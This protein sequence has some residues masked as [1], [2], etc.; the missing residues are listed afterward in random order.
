M[1]SFNPRSALAKTRR[2]IVGTRF[3][4]APMLTE[5]QLPRYCYLNVP[6]ARI[7]SHDRTSDTFVRQHGFEGPFNERQVAD[8]RHLTLGVFSCRL[9]S[10]LRG[11]LRYTKSPSI[12]ITRI[13]NDF[14]AQAT[15]AR[16]ERYWRNPSHANRHRA[17]SIK[18]AVISPA[19]PDSTSLSA[20][21][22]YKKM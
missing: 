6:H 12:N 20:S 9:P 17:G 10:W 3:A 8:T 16:R 13:D 18:F 15:I 21:T 4:S 2:T 14:V 5:H 19:S 1:S 11:S 7:G 22:T